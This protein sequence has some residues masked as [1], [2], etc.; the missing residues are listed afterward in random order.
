MYASR[1]LLPLREAVAGALR[2]GT[3]GGDL[4]ADDTEPDLAALWTRPELHARLVE[5]VG[6]HASARRAGA[7]VALDAAALPLA[8]PLSVRLG[9]PLVPPR[10]RTGR[11]GGTSPT[12][13]PYLVAGFLQPPSG[14]AP[15]RALPAEAG[16]PVGGCGVVRVGDPESGYDVDNFLS[17][18]EIRES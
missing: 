17:F 5:R 18:M 15:G 8:S 3:S 4:E 2:S 1:P 6:Q 9:L 7:I 12:E 11:P 16:S 13:R 10:G 14:R